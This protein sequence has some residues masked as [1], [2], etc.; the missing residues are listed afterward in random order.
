MPLNSFAT[1]KETLCRRDSNDGIEHIV[2]R[3]ATWNPLQE[4]RK[5]TPAQLFQQAD[6]LKDTFDIPLGKE[7]RRPGQTLPREFWMKLDDPILDGWVGGDLFF[8]ELVHLQHLGND[9]PHRK[10][11]SFSHDGFV[12][13]LEVMNVGCFDTWSW[14]GQKHRASFTPQRFLGTEIARTKFLSVRQSD[15]HVH[16]YDFADLGGFQNG[17]EVRAEL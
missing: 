11:C 2:K 8:K 16:G 15:G 10:S 3:R 6:P 17:F 5:P 12:H 4:G 7:V 9:P 13:R 1:I 14:W